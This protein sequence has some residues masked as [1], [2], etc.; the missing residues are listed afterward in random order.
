MEKI[1][2]ILH[3]ENILKIGGTVKDLLDVFPKIF[4]RVRQIKIFNN[5]R[6]VM[7]LE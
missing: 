6:F 1:A 5:V 7:N 4:Y 2:I 3:L